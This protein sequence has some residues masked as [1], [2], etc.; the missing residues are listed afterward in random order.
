MAVRDS[1][2]A[3]FIEAAGID[4]A[5]AR[6]A[7]DPLVE[8][9]PQC[10]VVTARMD[11]PV[12]AANVA[13]LLAL[14]QA[15]RQAEVPLRRSML[16]VAVSDGTAQWGSHFVIHHSVGGLTPVAHL[17][18]DVA[19]AAGADA[20]AGDS[21]MLYGASDIEFATPLTMLAVAHPELG[22]TVVD[23]GT[24]FRTTLDAFA[25]AIEN[26]PSLVLRGGGAGD[27]PGL[28]TRPVAAPAWR[29]RVLRLAHYLG[30]TLS[31][32]EPPPRWSPAGRRHL[33]ELPAPGKPAP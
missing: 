25:F 24:A 14:A 2:V 33:I 18:V 27:A 30:E 28:G 15:F 6:A 8:M 31:N 20:G 26:I 12:G 3:R 23:G 9:L 21:V 19:G 4:V 29:A 10:V 1:L 22:L 7:S 13:G 17:T 11:G 16:F 5:R 32:A